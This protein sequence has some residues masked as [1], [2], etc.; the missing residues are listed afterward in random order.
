VTRV[1]ICGLT[2]FEDVCAAVECGA[3][4]IGI[5]M[6]P[7]SPRFVSEAQHIQAL[8]NAIPPFVTSVAV[9]GESVTPVVKGFQAIQSLSSNWGDSSFLHIKAFRL[10]QDFLA[11]ILAFQNANAILLDSHVPGKLGGTGE[12][13]DW[14]LAR[15]VVE[16]QKLPV[17][18]AGGLTPNNVSEAIR[19]VRPYA[20][21]VSTGVESSPGVKDIGL[22]RRFIAEAKSAS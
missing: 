11:E 13:A 18:L 2:R 17:I 15:R 20:V 6:E 10:S 8:L 21:D 19:L 9:F 5:V 4:A 3:D 22:V 14:E 16:G 1:K 7:S 12:R